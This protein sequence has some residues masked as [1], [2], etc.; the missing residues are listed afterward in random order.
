MK[1]LVT[2]VAGF[3]GFHTA[4][5]LLARGEDVVGFDNLNSYYDIRLKEA[6]LNQLRADPRFT[7]IRGELAD[8]SMVNELFRQHDIGSAIHLAAQAGVRYSLKNPRAYVD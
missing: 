5:K 4:K 8:A 3:I 2:G 6:R 1:V 7:F